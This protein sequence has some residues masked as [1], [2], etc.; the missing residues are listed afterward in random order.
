MFSGKK[1][2]G[3]RCSVQFSLFAQ[4]CFDRFKLLPNE[5]IDENYHYQY[6]DPFYDEV[7]VFF[8]NWSLKFMTKD[9][10]K[11][12]VVPYKTIIRYKKKGGKKRIGFYGL[13]ILLSSRAKIIIPFQKSRRSRP[14]FL[15]KLKE[16][17]ENIYEFPKKVWKTDDNWINN[18]VNESKW[19]RIKNDFSPTYPQSILIPNTLNMKTVLKC[20]KYRSKQRIP[21]LAYL[22]PSN[23]CV[24]LRSS[25]PLT[26]LLGTESKADQEYIKALIGDKNLSILD[27]RPKINAVANQF[28]GGGYESLESFTEIKATFDFLDI[29]NIHKV[30]ESFLEIKKNNSFENWGTL[31]LQIIK[32]A[33]LGSKKILDG[34]SVLVHCTDGWDRT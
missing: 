33:I 29:P 28:T 1:N 3:K 31:I 25:Q 23:N 16:K 30:R 17:M 8:S 24:L 27:C 9:E 15:K 11:D 19:V 32:G 14:N 5:E 20:S 2:K 10:N 34:T 6:T 13:S 22:M 18:L 12:F 4:Q 26:G 7:H 21:I